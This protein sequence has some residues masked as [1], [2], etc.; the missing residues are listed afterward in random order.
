MLEN[1]V[2]PRHEAD[3]FTIEMTDGVADLGKE[4]AAKIDKA[5]K[6]ESKETDSSADSSEEI[7]PPE[8][9]DKKDVPVTSVED[10]EQKTDAEPAKKVEKE[11]EKTAEVS[12]AK[13][14]TLDSIEAKLVS[15]TGDIQRIQ[16][17]IWYTRIALAMFLVIT[18]IFVKLCISDVNDTMGMFL[19][20]MMSTLQ[21]TSDGN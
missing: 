20:F 1:K 9:D 12:E 16:K 6:D 18:L 8:N 3:D 4:V 15:L 17:E 10:K 13:P 2:K 11:V 21:G 14:A 5:S 19:Q 7:L